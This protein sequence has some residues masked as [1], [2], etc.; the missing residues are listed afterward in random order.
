VDV[1][2]G[3]SHVCPFQDA[4]TGS[5][6]TSDDVVL[7]QDSYYRTVTFGTTMDS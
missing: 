2:H 6:A 5:T 7:V 4:V 1:R 3:R